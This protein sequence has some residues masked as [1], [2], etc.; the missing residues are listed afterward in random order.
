METS[1]GPDV[2]KE[3]IDLVHLPDVPLGGMIGC[4]E[5]FFPG[6][7]VLLVSHAEFFGSLDYSWNIISCLSFHNKGC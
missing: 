1:E 2:E 3:E 5:I 6:V 4:L 7:L